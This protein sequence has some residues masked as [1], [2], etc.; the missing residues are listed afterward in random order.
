MRG[1]ETAAPRPG[2]P[3]LGSLFLKRLFPIL[4]FLCLLSLKMK[5]CAWM[6]VLPL[7]HKHEVRMAHRLGLR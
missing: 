4:G 6:A 2:C 1:A 7:T 3:P 5:E